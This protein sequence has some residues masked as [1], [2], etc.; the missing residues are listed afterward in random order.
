M[1]EFSQLAENL[2]PCQFKGQF[3]RFNIARKRKLVTIFADL[4]LA[5]LW[6]E[7]AQVNQKWPLICHLFST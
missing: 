2:E 4:F 7:T 6:M 1:A 3:R 5:L